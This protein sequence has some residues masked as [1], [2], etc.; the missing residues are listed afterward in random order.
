MNEKVYT[1]GICEK[2][3]IRLED[4]L[5]CVYM[6]GEKLK[7]EQEEIE[8]KKRAEELNI[9][10]S[11]VKAAKAYYEQQLNDFKEKYPEEYELNFGKT[12]ECSCD[13]D[14]C[15]C[16]N[17]SDL[18][19]AKDEIENDKIDSISISYVDNGKDKPQ[20]SAKVNGAKVDENSLSKLF[21]DPDTQ[22]I[23]RMLGIL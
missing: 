12:H 4:Y 16:K 7:K 17:D 3:H 5:K 8:L 2:E 9:A 10:I 18:A 21:K 15:N 1:C 11:K 19:K 6:C 13:K 23:A 14:T 22:Y 20:L